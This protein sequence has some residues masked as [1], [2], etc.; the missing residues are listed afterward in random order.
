M[1]PNQLNYNHILMTQNII[2]KK[3]EKFNASVA[4]DPDSHIK[5]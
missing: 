3:C 2:F 4:D 5:S 1:I